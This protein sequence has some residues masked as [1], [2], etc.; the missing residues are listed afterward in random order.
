M[1]HVQLVTGYIYRHEEHFRRGMEE[2]LHAESAKQINGRL[3][4]YAAKPDV[5][6]VSLIE[7][8]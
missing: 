7:S 1:E 3:A 5:G 6:I 4:E 2:Q 8:I